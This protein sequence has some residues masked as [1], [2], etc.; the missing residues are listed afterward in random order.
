M[1]REYRMAE[2]IILAERRKARKQ[3]RATNIMAMP[4]ALMAAYMAFGAATCAAIVEVS[5]QSYKR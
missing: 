1:G 3:R 4:F 5:Q 2:I